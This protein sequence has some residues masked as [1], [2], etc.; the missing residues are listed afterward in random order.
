MEKPAETLRKLDNAV[1]APRP[2]RRYRA[3]VFQLYLLIASAGFVVLAVA[4]RFIPYFPIDLAITRAVQ[5]YHGVAFDRMMFGMSWIG[6]LPQ[7]LAFGFIPLVLLF[8]AGLRWEA[9]AG[10]MAVASSGVAGLVKFVVHRP[11]PSIDLVHVFHELAH[12]GFPSGHVLTFS[13][14]CGYFAFLAHTLLKP[15]WERTAVL[16]AVPVLCL[17]MGLSRIYQGQHWFSD[18]AGAYLLATLWLALVIRVYRWGKP[19]FFVHQPVAPEAPRT[20]RGS[21]PA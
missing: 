12:S 18:V 20:E 6:F 19:R 21:A 2:T 11:R 9:V 10:L 15:S 7:S 13:A 5:S 8:A 3:A 17:L 1:I 14:I 4:A 16:A